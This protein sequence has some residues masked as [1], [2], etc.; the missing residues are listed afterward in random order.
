MTTWLFAALA[1]TAA[2]QNI[3]AQDEV[4]ASGPVPEWAVLSDPLPVPDTARG[5]VF[6]RRQ[7]SEIHLDKNGQSNFSA[8]TMHL[9]EASALQAGNVAVAW[10]P[11]A[12]KPVIHAL[13]VYRNGQARDVL[14]TTKFTILR[15]EDRLEAAMLD[16]MLT[17]TLK[18]P[19]L[20]VGDDLEFI[21]TVPGQDPT[22]RDQSSGLLLMAPSPPPGRY[23][24]RIS[25]DQGQQPVVRPT[26]DLASLVVKGDRSVL[27]A[28]DNPGPLNP[29]KDAPGRYNWQ[30]LIEFTDFAD[31]RA[32][33]ARIA[34]LFATAA[35]LPANSP[36]KQ[37]AAAIAGSTSDPLARAQAALKLVQQQ[38]RYVYV[39]LNGG[40]LTPAT[41]DETWQRRYGDC[42]AK[43]VLLLA[44]LKELGIAAQPIL[45]SN[46]GNDDG[47]DQRLPSPLLFDHV[48]V[49][50]TIAGKSYWLDGTLPPQYAPSEKPLLPYKW[51]LPISSAGEGLLNLPWQPETKP[52][53]VSLFEIDARAGFA[54]PAKIRQVSIVR[55][56]QA[57]LLYY[58]FS[59]ISDEQLQSAFKQELEGSET[60]NTVDSVTW[61]FDPSELASV[62]E[63]KG[64]GPVDWKPETGGGKSLSLPG[65][66]F[67]PP[68]RRQR[69]TGSDAPFAIKPDFDCKVTT[70]RLPA[71]TAAAD[72]TYN[73]TYNTTIYGQSFRRSF[74]LRDGSLR[75]M[76]VNRTL[77]NEISSEAAAKDTLRLPRFDNSMAW[78]QYRQGTAPESLI[79]ERVPATFERDWVADASAC[80]STTFSKP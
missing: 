77:Q 24:L 28:V 8:L 10:N 39:G 30:R 71:S 11:A 4:V 26:K 59:A 48:L 62:L 69:G 22:L 17:A 14:A 43:T 76:R 56:V 47:L 16:G 13:R 53:E 42:K 7:A 34:P 80:L 58:Q 23:S 75:M 40:N 3:P 66:G 32:V 72:W 46:D 36:L 15:R 6:V 18:V 31:W 12:G 5:P 38:I 33:S 20:R 52:D 19:D 79:V 78:A 64:T 73:S 45:A 55:G 44:L 70:L 54:P 27:Y 35:A 50:A 65:G 74:E 41:A 68:E 49:R 57:V 21:Y 67:S 51:T 25:W 37:E 1:T 29:P 9:L 2:I 61:R 60:W 63:I